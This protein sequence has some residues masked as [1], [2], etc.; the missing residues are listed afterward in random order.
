VSDTKTLH[1]HLSLN[2]S[3]GSAS[4]LRLPDTE[5]VLFKST[6]E[7][8]SLR[9]R[10]SRLIPLPVPPGKAKTRELILTSRRLICLKQRLKGAGGISIKSE[11]ALRASEKLKEKDKEKESR[12]IVASVERKGEREFV[13][14]TVGSSLPLGS[15][16]LIAFYE[17]IKIL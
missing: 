7:A 17:V 1:N 13:V 5:V 14:L 4:I 12:G 6:V 3:V 15:Y 2:C 8:R 11:L 10:A 9:R 16:H